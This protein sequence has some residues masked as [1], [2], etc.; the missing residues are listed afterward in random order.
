MWIGTVLGQDEYRVRSGEW[1]AIAEQRR[2]TEPAPGASEVFVGG[3]SSTLA[4]KFSRLQETIQRAIEAIASTTGG[5]AEPEC[6]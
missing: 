2:L 4:A 6:C 1:K 5:P 3:W